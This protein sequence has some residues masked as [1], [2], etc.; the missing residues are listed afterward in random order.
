MFNADDIQARVRQRPF[1]PVRIA[2]SAGQ[3]FD[4]YHPDL[5][6]VGRR[7]VTV[8]TASTENS[9]QYDRQTRI[10]IIH[11]TALEDLPTPILP[12]GNGQQQT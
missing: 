6:M 3:A 12:G 8:G 11:V 1:V 10:A 2:T 5:I 4:I 7:D 9:S